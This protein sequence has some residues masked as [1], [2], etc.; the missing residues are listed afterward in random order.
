MN[1]LKLLLITPLL[2]GGFSTSSDVKYANSG[3]TDIEISSAITSNTSLFLKSNYKITTDFKVDNVL[4]VTV[5]DEIGTDNRTSRLYYSNSLISEYSVIKNPTGGSSVEYINIANEVKARE[6]LGSQGEAI[7]FDLTY[8]NPLKNFANLNNS[9]INSYFDITSE[10]G[11]YILKATSLAYGSLTK[12]IINFFDDLSALVWDTSTKQE[13]IEDLEIVLNEYGEPTNMSFAKITKDRF[14][15]IRKTFDCTIEPISSLN[16]LK[17]VE[18]SL[19]EDESA[20]FAAKLNNFQEMISKGNFTQTFSVFNGEQ[21]YNNFYALNEDTTSILGPMMMSDMPLIEQNYGETF[22]GL[23][24]TPEGFQQYAVSPDANMSGQMSDTKY[25][26]IDMVIPDFTAI[27][28]DFFHLENGKYV[29]D[30]SS[31]LHADTTFSADI[32][33]VLMSFVDPGVSIAGLYLNNY[34]YTFNKLTY[35]FNSDGILTGTLQYFI[36]TYLLETT[37]TFKNIGTTDLESEP[38]I[39]SAIDYL[40]RN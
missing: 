6:L 22:V 8:G 39:A 12:N 19:S 23:V 34:D 21:T 17:P 38:S 4:D 20:E 28:T 7:L 36:E 16:T 27:S 29:F 31:F 37:F 14:G 3:E 35:S 2:L 13:E 25:S 32:L 5:V 1:K 30:I 11:K 18:A 24:S 10:E 9:K 26:S 33:T 15:A 40:L